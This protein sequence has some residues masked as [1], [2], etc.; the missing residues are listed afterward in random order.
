MILGI[1]KHVAQRIERYYSSISDRPSFVRRLFGS[2]RTDP[3]RYEHVIVHSDAEGYY[4]P[5][6]FERVIFPAKALKIPG[7]MIGSVPRL[8]QECRGLA[9]LLEIPA[10]LDIESDEVLEAAEC[11]GSGKAKWQQ[12]GIESFSCLRLM[13]ACEASLKAGA[14]IVF[15]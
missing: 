2:R 8:L 12:Y 13:A 14:A 11:P 7:G 15:C 1:L 10:G 6:D 5:Q 9:K 3:L 4:V